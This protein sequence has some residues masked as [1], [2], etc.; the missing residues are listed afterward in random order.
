MPA[1]LGMRVLLAP[2]RLS[3]SSVASSPTMT[4]LVALMAPPLPD[5]VNVPL[6]TVVAPVY[7]LEAAN[8]TRPL[9]AVTTSPLPPMAPE[10]V[11][12]PEPPS[13]SVWPPLLTLPEMV[14]RL[15]ELFAQVCDEPI[16][17]GALIVAA[18]AP[19]L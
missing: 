16:A 14:S 2:P 15:E 3:T 5:N 10:I 4:P 18:P 11:V 1:A 9:P 19:G 17:T 12:A 13:V 8:T 7:V 6:L